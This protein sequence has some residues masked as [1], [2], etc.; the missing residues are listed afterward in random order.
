MEYLSLQFFGI[1]FAVVI[2]AV[3][4]IGSILG[5][6]FAISLAP[7]GGLYNVSPIFTVKAAFIHKRELTLH[8]EPHNAKPSNKDLFRTFY[9][10]YFELESGNIIQLRLKEDECLSLVIGDFG[11]LTYQG[12]R[13][14]KFERVKQNKGLS[15]NPVTSRRL[16]CLSTYLDRYSQPRGFYD[17][18]WKRYLLPVC[19]HSNRLGLV[20]RPAN[21]R[22]NRRNFDSRP[23]SLQSDRLGL[24]GCPAKLRNSRQG[25]FNCPAKRPTTSLW[26]DGSPAYLRSNRQKFI[27]CPVGLRIKRQKLVRQPAKLRSRRRTSLRNS[28][29]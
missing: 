4:F 5:L 23:F 16:Q 3:I 28:K 6:V 12:V 21:L 14:K 7:F 27:G 11:R 10:A 13:F 29:V 2:I 20:V 19:V 15:R 25:L 1:D 24:S 9:Y 22:S 18:I 26:L 17:K 8:Y